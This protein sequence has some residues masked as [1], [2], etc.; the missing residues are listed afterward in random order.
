MDKC[1]KTLWC[2]KALVKNQY[3]YG[4]Y[5]LVHAV[6]FDILH[7]LWHISSL[8]QL[9]LCYLHVTIKIE[10]QRKVLV[11]CMKFCWVGPHYSQ[12]KSF[13]CS[14]C[15]AQHHSLHWFSIAIIA[16]LDT[17]T[18]KKIL[19]LHWDWPMTDGHAIAP[20]WPQH[21]LILAIKKNPPR[22]RASICFCISTHK[23][24]CW[25]GT[26]LAWLKNNC[27]STSLYLNFTFWCMFFLTV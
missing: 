10:W 12:G 8:L 17:L 13:P 6:T 25:H 27:R 7:L 14:L 22:Y 18:K 15:L 20:S 3:V 26:R 9:V 5:M 4:N 11:K 24:S 2:T 23:H 19:G 21:A 1:V 16:Y